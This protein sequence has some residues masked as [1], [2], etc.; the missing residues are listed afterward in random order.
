VATECPT[1][2]ATPLARVEQLRVG[3]GTVSKRST[4][5]LFGVVKKLSM[6]V[7]FFV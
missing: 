7:F 4:S 3:L 1:V 6:S 2:I 5:S